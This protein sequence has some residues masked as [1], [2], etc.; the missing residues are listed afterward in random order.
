M[1][2]YDTKNMFF[3]MLLN[4]LIPNIRIKCFIMN[5]KICYVVYKH[6]YWN[7]NFHMILISYKKKNDLVKDIIK[8]NI[9]SYNGFKMNKLFIHLVLSSNAFKMYVWLLTICH[10]KGM[11]IVIFYLWGL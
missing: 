9:K 4:N 1:R 10:C 8:L 6:F 3:F 7:L 2:E 5:K 11:Q